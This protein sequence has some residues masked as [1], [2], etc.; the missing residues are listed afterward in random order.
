MGPLGSLSPVKTQTL[1]DVRDGFACWRTKS[2]AKL[3]MSFVVGETKTLLELMTCCLPREE[4]ESL[5]LRLYVF[6]RAATWKTYAEVRFQLNG[7]KLL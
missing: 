7:R 5:G 2:V 4:N 6:A 3:R 1:E